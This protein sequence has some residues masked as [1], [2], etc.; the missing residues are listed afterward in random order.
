M[1]NILC[2]GDSN[3]FGFVPLDGS[4]YDADKR[5]SGILKKSLA[6][7]YNVIEAGCNNRTCIADN[8]EGP[9]FTGY[10]AIAPYLE[11][12]PDLKLVVLGLGIN[13][14]QFSYKLS[15]EEVGKGLQ[16]LIK[17]I[18]QKTNAKILVLIPNIIGSSILA[19]FFSQMFDETSIEK[20]KQLPELFKNIAEKTKSDFLDLNTFA[21]PSEKDGL[22]YDE[23]M[24][25]K[26]AEAAKKKIKEIL[27]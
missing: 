25:K 16:R 10:K 2:F 22:H 11:N 13:D 15:A 19:S 26:I 8:P 27:L 21:A 12:H 20:S 4:R 6:G 24:H 18:K 14:L 1:K 9:L 3:T 5:W 23:E 7:K 17:D